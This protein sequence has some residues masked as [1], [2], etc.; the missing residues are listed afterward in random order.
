VEQVTIRI[1]VAEPAP[2]G[3][4]TLRALRR[5]GH[6]AE[7]Q[8]V[9]DA[10]SCIA[11]VGSGGFD[12]VVAD[13]TL[14]AEGTR[15]LAA[16]RRDGPPIVV[17]TREPGDA[18][19]LDWFRRGAVDCVAVR[20]GFA[21]AL[22]LVALEHVERWRR[23]RER[24][25]AARRIRELERYNENIIQ[26]MNSALLVVDM[27]GRITSCNPPAEQ[28]LGEPGEALRGR[29]ISEWFEK[30]GQ[31]DLVARTLAEGTRF[32][33]AERVITRA[34][35]RVVPIGISCAPIF[36]GDG[37]KL[38]A[39]ATFQD[40]TEIREL[41]RQVLQTEKMASIGQLAAGVA[42][43]I[44]N[45][46]GFIHAN[47]FQM[48]EYL[49]DLRRVWARVDDLQKAAAEGDLALV[50]PA[51]ESLAAAAEE[52]DVDFLL[53]D[54][55]KAIR[56][57]QEGS[58]RIRHIVQDLRDFS[59]HE[60]GECVLTDLNQ[61]LDSTANIVWPMMKHL[62]VLEKGYQDLPNIYCFPM[63]L[64]QVFMNLLVNACQA[65]EERVGD[66]GEVGKI[67][68]RTD[69]RGDHVMVTVTDT[70][71]GIAP[72]N[73]DRIFDPFFT[74]KKVGTGMGLGLSTS[75]N[76]IQ[77]HGGSLTVESTLDQG[78]TFRVLLPVSG[79]EEPDGES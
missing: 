68:L 76:I 13:E 69:Q 18:G 5:L 64:K 12:L 15:I 10:D 51:A 41:Q 17:V 72:E 20:E 71:T 52:A 27:E 14:G 23:L 62:V 55:A 21:D 46:M 48:A 11:R 50:K 47:L 70:G 25:A 3:E 61:C 44:N 4:E 8:V 38:G 60:T 79:P 53:S 75:Y 7:I 28:T 43:E 9:H 58:E 26:N 36:D 42:H 65:I 73:I 49:G 29:P 2:C 66:S 1:L 19:A 33:G 34:D 74:T 45:P 59:H 54:L 39:A 40:L 35:G 6:E 63:Q 57:S 32:K 22:P 56:E 31:E 30:P 16:L 67:W 24:G 78:T 37:T 77:R